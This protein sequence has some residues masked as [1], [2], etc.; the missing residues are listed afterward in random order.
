MQLGTEV[1]RGRVHGHRVGPLSLDF[2]GLCRLACFSL[3]LVLQLIERHPQHGL[4][5]T[6]KPVHVSLPG[7]LVDDVLVVVVA[8]TPAQ[9]L[10]VHLGLVLP[11]APPA[12]HLLG[13]DQ[14]E[15]PLAAGPGDAVLAVAIRQQLEEKLPQLDGARACWGKE[16]SWK[17]FS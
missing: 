8:E 9:F 16:K 2:N 1:R 4:E 6:D 14:F 10:V 15:L 17:N 7:H 12:G 3:Q 5:V 11:R 13:V